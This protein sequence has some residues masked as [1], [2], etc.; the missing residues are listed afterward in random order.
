MCLLEA[1]PTD[2]WDIVWC[3]YSCA[4]TARGINRT[5][6]TFM[7]H[8]RPTPA[9]RQLSGHPTSKNCP[10]ARRKKIKLKNKFENY[11]MRYLFCFKKRSGVRKPSLGAT[12]MAQNIFPHQSS[13]SISASL[14]WKPPARTTNTGLAVGVRILLLPQCWL[15]YLLS[16]P[17][18]TVYFRMM[19][20]IPI[21][22]V[23]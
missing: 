23:K 1:F 2:P 4:T 15:Q 6:L 11:N 7:L 12:V 8:P 20:C 13:Y 10:R 19:M 3:N 16:R 9:S 17:H 21:P 5:I 22:H 18:G 14:N